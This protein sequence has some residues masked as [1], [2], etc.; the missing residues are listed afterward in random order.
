MN[1]KMVCWLDRIWPKRHRFV[2]VGCGTAWDR[3]LPVLVL[4]DLFLLPVLRSRDH[5]TEVAVV[6]SDG[7]TRYKSTV[8]AR[9]IYEGRLR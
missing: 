1:V 8:C 7:K 9:I 3:R 2:C 5:L 4:G 6:G